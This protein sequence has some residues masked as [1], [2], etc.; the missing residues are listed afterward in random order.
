MTSSDA[1][2]ALTAHFA[3]YSRPADY[4]NRAHCCE[5]EEHYLELLDVPVEC[6]THEH[7]GD[8]AWD[9]TAF[10]TPDAFRYYLPGLAR[11]ADSDREVWLE[12]FVMRIGLHYTETCNA[13]DW[14]AITALLEGWWCDESV[15]E[16]TRHALEGALDLSRR[17]LRD[18]KLR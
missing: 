18:R 12:L 11:I 10:L 14:H 4:I 13:D 16:W 17:E 15:P 1:L 6:L 8:G 9:P 2:A 5:C 7:T 3:Q